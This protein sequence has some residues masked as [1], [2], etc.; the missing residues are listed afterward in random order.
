MII[1]YSNLYFTPQLDYPSSSLFFFFV[2]GGLGLGFM[3]PFPQTPV[4]KKYI[5]ISSLYKEI[6]NKKIKKGFFFFFFSLHFPS[7]NPF[8][9]FLT[10]LSHNSNRG[11]LGGGIS[12]SLP[13]LSDRFSHV[14][15]CD[16]VLA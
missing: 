6:K 12:V 14:N 4:Q 3:Y 2:G 13:F 9:S 16:D 7:G 11:R 10:A 8:S 15:V 1:Y 5:Y